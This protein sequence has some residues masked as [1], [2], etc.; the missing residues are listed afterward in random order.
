M[1]PGGT[2]CTRKPRQCLPPTST[3]TAQLSCSA[4]AACSS[5]RS[6]A[7]TC[8]SPGITAN[9]DGPWTTQQIRNLLMDLG[10]HAAG[11]KFLVRDRAG[12]FTASFDAAV[13][14][15][16]IQAAKIPPRNPR[17]NA[18][19]ERFALTART[20]ITDRML[21]FSERHLRSV[22]TEYARHSTGN[23]LTAAASSTRPGLTTPSPTSRTSG[24]SADP[25]SAVSSTNT[26][27]PRRRPGQHRWPSSGTP[28]GRCAGRP[29]HPA[30]AAGQRPLSRPRRG[31]GRLRP[32][33]STLL[34][35]ECLCAR[36]REE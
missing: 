33:L 34:A 32:R 21:I 13:A 6:A 19:A 30:A 23:G 17:A 10:D 27:E 26:G 31:T 18:Y 12:Q 7:A 3:W 35:G 16:G 22:L 1:R 11:F 36:A 28:Q 8:T 15:T 20:E 5:S 24:S 9:P 14:S 25:S 2:A 29:P 4:C